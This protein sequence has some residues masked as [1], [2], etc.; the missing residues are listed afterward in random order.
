MSGDDIIP[1]SS[2]DAASAPWKKV[3]DR[4]LRVS[5]MRR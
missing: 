5:L 2:I 4:R 3:M 1:S